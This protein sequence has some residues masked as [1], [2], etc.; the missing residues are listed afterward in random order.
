MRKCYTIDYICGGYFYIKNK[1][2]LLAHYFKVHPIYNQRRG[3]F[4]MR[5][6]LGLI[7]IL[8]LM[9]LAACS[10]PEEE[11]LLD[12]HN[13]IVDK[14]KPKLDEIEELSNDMYNEISMAETDEEVY[15]VL[16]DFYDT[17]TDEIIPLTEEVQEFYDSQELETED[18]Q[19]YHEMRKDAATKLNEAISIE[20]ETYGKLLEDE[21]TEDEFFMELVESEEMAEEAIEIDNEADE[22]WDE[23]SD[24]YDFEEIAEDD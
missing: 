10:S 22:K 4:R 19:E 2:N 20:H 23:L 15:N 24:E 3:E 1:R 7:S 9:V 11:E 21:I 18:A 13:D 12:Y 5:K 17:F 8:L 16:N 14:V 6:T